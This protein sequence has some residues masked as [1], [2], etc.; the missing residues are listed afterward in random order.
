LIPVPARGSV[1]AVANPLYDDGHLVLDEDGLTIRRYYFP[2]AAA[3]RIPYTEIRHV[4]VR[5]MGWLTGRGRGW[6]S[7][8]PGYWLPLDLRR[9]AKRILVVLDVGHRV[10]PCVTPDDP[11]RFIELLQGRVPVG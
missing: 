7:A 2:L 6:G 5:P 11:D 10:K 3:K 4:T 1:A 8:H 9:A